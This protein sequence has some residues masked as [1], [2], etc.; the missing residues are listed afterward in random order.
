MKLAALQQQFQDFLLQAAP[1]GSTLGA[2]IATQAILP[3]EDRLAIYYNAY[4]IRLRE[5]LDEAFP[6]TGAYLGDDLFLQMCEAFVAAHPSTVRN[7]RWYG[8]QFPPF[9]AGELGQHPQVA[10]LAAF[11]WALGLAFDADDA[12]VLGADDVR[13][14]AP[15]AWADLSFALHPS[16]HML[17]LHSNAV[18][19]W[20]ALD[21]DAEPPDPAHSASAHHWLV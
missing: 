6:K 17:D 14:L 5:A 16:A 12:P 13:Q 10:E 1:G 2:A 4:R 11:E 18:A 19:I 20:Q 15:E 3:A 21:R 9:L 7:L 8:A